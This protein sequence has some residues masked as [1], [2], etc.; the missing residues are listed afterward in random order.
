MNEV[1]RIMW[2]DGF[3]PLVKETIKKYGFYHPVVGYN[4]SVCELSCFPGYHWPWEYVR[5]CVK[6]K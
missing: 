6:M 4:E 5:R 2:C 1:V 3:N